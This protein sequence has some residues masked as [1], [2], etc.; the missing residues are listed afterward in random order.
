MRICVVICA[1]RQRCSKLAIG[2]V[3]ALFQST[4]SVFFFHRFFVVAQIE[5]YPAV[6]SGQSDDLGVAVM[7]ILFITSPNNSASYHM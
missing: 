1:L 7:Y 3:C 4:R 2:L 6:S 5:N